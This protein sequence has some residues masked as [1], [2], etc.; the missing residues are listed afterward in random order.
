M[1]MHVKVSGSVSQKKYYFVSIY[2]LS[3]AINFAWA[4]Q[5]K[6]YDPRKAFLCRVSAS[7]LH[8]FDTGFL[9][10]SVPLSLCMIG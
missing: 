7:V 1:K 2:R 3:G 6:I 8:S 10:G 5:N 4:N 9:S